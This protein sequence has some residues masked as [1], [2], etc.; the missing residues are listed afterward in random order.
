MVTGINDTSGHTFFQRFTLT[1]GINYD[2]GH[3]QYKQYQL[4]RPDRKFLKNQSIISNSIMKN[5]CCGS[6][7]F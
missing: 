5:Q 4:A 3:Q 7:A 1:A 6:M 2:T